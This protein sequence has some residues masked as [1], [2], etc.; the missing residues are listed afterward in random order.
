MSPPRLITAPRHPPRL[1][2][3][4]PNQSTQRHPTTQIKRPTQLTI[5]DFMT[6]P[7]PPAPPTR[8]TDLS[9][10]ASSSSQ[11]SLPDPSLDLTP[12]MHPPIAE[13]PP[14]PL[15]RNLLQDTTNEPWGNFLQYHKPQGHF[16]VLSKNISTLNSQHLDM[17]AIAH[18]LQQCDASIFLAQETNTPWNPQNLATVKSQCQQVHRHKKIATSSSTDSAKGTYQPGGTLT[19]ALGKWASRVI[20]WG[21]DDPLGRWSY[22]ELVG[23]HGMRLIVVSAYRVCPQQFDATTSTVTAQQTR[24]LLQQGVTNPNP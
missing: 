19:L 10:P 16:R 9:P 7:T 4:I 14:L 13:P 8:A 3:P 12:P 20:K 23:Q 2:T 11:S 17:V 21:S 18:E 15:Q 22:L 1:N 5:R 24:L 6:R